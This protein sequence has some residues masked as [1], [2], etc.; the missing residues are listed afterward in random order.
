MA[1]NW[2]ELT[3]SYNGV[4]M[5]SR[6]DT[7]INNEQW[8]GNAHR[9]NRVDAWAAFG[10]AVFSNLQNYV[11]NRQIDRGFRDLERENHGVLQA[12]PANK[13]VIATIVL[14]V[15]TQTGTSSSSVDYVDLVGPPYYFDTPAEGIN[16]SQREAR[17]ES[18]VNMFRH[19]ERRYFW[20]TLRH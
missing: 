2:Y 11:V 19:K 18:G 15:T 9:Q 10:L 17:I 14:T 8:A 3:V 5:A 20:G 4:T 16:Q 7:P 6:T 13:G 12:I 1:V